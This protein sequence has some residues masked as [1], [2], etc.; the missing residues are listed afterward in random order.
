MK[1]WRQLYDAI[2]SNFDHLDGYLTLFTPLQRR[3][4]RK[5]VEILGTEIRDFLKELFQVRLARHN[6][7]FAATG[8]FANAKIVGFPSSFYP[9]FVNLVD[10]AIFWFIATESAARAKQLNSMREAARC[11]SQIAD[12]ASMFVTGKRSSNSVSAEN[13]AGVGWGC[14]SDEKP[15]AVWGSTYD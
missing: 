14:T 10:N 4:Y 5:A 3:L 6:V 12:R 7:A 2:R 11:S 9:V 8:N 13:P 1:V 15:C